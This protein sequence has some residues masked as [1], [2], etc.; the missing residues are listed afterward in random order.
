MAI[1]VRHPIALTTQPGAWTFSGLFFIESIA[2]AAM[3]TVL[4]LTAYARFGSKEAVSLVYTAVSLT[5]LALSFGI[6]V[7]VRRISRRWTYTLGCGLLALCGVLTWLETPATVAAA[8]L[9]RTTGA[10]ALNITLSLYIM[11]NIGRRDLAR[12]ESLRFAVSTLA[13]TAM[14]VVGVWLA[15]RFGLGA[16]CLVCIAAAGVLAATFWVLRLAEG[17][18]IRAA[19]GRP[20]ALHN[21]LRAVRRFAGQPRL[22]LAWSIAFARSSFWASFFVYAPILMVE[23]GRSAAAGALVVAAGN[24]MLLN[25]LFTRAW[26]SR[27]SLRR[28]IGVALVVAAGLVLLAA[29]LSRGA[30]LM[31]G[32]VL[33]G[34]SF[35]VAMLDGLG[36]VPFLRA[37]RAHERA[38]MTTVYRTY[39]DASELLP[40]IAYFFLFML[41]G[42]TAAFAGLACLMGV[43]G[44]LVLRHL[45]R[46]M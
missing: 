19:T 21:P 1:H 36:P 22:V 24:L 35:F 12:T 14:P 2:R 32:A 43:I 3:A 15:T 33:V 20:V 7:M 10:A 30:P 38:E 9:A 25:N 41:G 28:V 39:L 6:P 44:L 42:F 45:P 17:G 26:A 11:D 18:A 34:A 4:P 46:G 29:V 31:A 37:V 5:A 27:F 23:G 40:Q 16:A 13:W 8:L